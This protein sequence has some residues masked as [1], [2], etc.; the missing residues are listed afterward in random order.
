LHR[1][2]GLY[3]S[4]FERQIQKDAES[5]DTHQPEDERT[6]AEGVDPRWQRDFRSLPGDERF[7][8]A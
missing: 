2:Y 5:E 4:G 7:V 8:T 6:A 3:G 1:S